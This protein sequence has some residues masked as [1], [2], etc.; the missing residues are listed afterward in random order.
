M[1][2]KDKYLP[3]IELLE[4]AGTGSPIV[5]REEQ[6]KLLLV[7]TVHSETE[8]RIVWAKIKQIGGSAPADLMA[9]IRVNGEDMEEDETEPGNEGDN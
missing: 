3:V 7:A 1:S 6:D 2:V 9:D 5:I 8:K 4:I